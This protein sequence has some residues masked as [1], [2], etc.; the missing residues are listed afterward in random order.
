MLRRIYISLCSAM[1]MCLTMLTGCSE[2][3]ISIGNGRQEQAGGEECFAEEAG[4]EWE[5]ILQGGSLGVKMLEAG[6]Q[7]SDNL[8]E[9]EISE[10]QPEET[11][12]QY[13]EIVKGSYW[14]EPVFCSEDC[15]CAFNGSSYGFVTKAGKEITP[16]M[17]QWAEPF[18]EGLAC[19]CLDGKY[20]YIGKDGETVLPFIYDQASS[21]TDGLAY[22]REGEDYGFID[23]EG[24]IVLQPDCDSISSFQENRAYFSVDGL[25]GYMDK[26][27]KIIV[28]PVYEDAGYFWDGLAKVMQKGCYGLIGIDGEEILATEYDAIRAQGDFII[29]EKDT[30]TYCFDREGRP[31]PQEVRDR[32]DAEKEIDRQRSL[33][34]EILLQNHITP[35]VEAYMDFLQNGIIGGDEKYPVYI[36][37]L[38]Q[39]CRCFSKLYRMEETGELALYFYAEPYIQPPFPQSDSGFFVFGNGEMEEIMVCSECGGSMRGDYIC[40]WYD[41]EED[42]LRLGSRGLWGGFGGYSFD[43]AVYAVQS[44]GVEEIA[45]FSM[46]SYFNIVDYYTPEYLQENAELFYDWDNTPY[47]AESIAGVN[48]VRIF[49][50]DGTQTT[51]EH[52]QEAES[53]YRYMDAL[54]LR[55]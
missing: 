17:Y 53:R 20:G 14:G 54:D 8:S 43:E 36:S 44:R 25:Y 2:N 46:V 18:S 10:T 4:E 52:Y 34:L 40:F 30:F 23:H 12:P 15:Y 50:V 38:R 1:L 49:S 48:S 47:T 19:V 45:G 55:Y 51:I 16:Y 32:T 29:A 33:R 31:C 6:K 35:R 3:E 28:E 24:N 21:F 41:R 27:G 39:T 5:K 26:T 22:V 7:D 13:P 11:V 9:P 37:E 42:R